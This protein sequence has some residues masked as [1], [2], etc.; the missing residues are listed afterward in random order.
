MLLLDV[1]DPVRR[2]GTGRTIDWTAAAAI[3][4]QRRDPAG[5]RADAGQRRR[6][7]RARAAV[8][9]RRVVGRGTLARHQGSPAPA[10][11]VRGGAWHQSRHG[12]ILT[13]AATSAS[14]AGASCPKRWSSR[15]KS[16]SAR[17]SR[18]ATIRR[19]GAELDRLLKHY[20]GR[21]TPVYEATRLAEACRRRADL[22]EAR[23]PDAHRRAQDQQRARPGAARRPHGQ[24]PHRRRNRRRAARRR[25]RDRVRAA[26]PR[27]PRLHGRRGHGAAGAERVPHAAARRRGAAA[28]TPAAAR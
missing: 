24:A 19:S 4:A 28:S 18:R 21:P 5:R 26:R 13:R 25:D 8:R 12:A 17:T 15:S 23:G 6:R 16:S 11:A 14:S 10:G 22:P 2:G 1:H 20:V 27:V 9:H 3:A 7:G